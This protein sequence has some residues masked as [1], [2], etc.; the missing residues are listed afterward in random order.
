MSGAGGRVGFAGAGLA[1]A[2]AA[3]A[4]GDLHGDAAAPP[5]PTRAAAPR[6]AAAASNVIQVPS[7]VADLQSAIAQVVNGG[8]I[9]LANGTYASPTGGWVI[10]DRG[11]A[12]T[13]RAA[14]GATVV[15]DGGGARDIVRLINSSVAAGRPVTFESLVFNNGRS[16]TDGIAGG[17]TV[18]RGQATFVGCT[19]Q[20]NRSDSNTGGGGT[21]VAVGSTAFF[22]DCLWNN[23]SARTNGGGLAL[24]TDSRAVIHR[25]RFTNNRTNLPNHLAT[26]AGGAIHVVNSSLRLSNTRFTGNQAG[27]VG[28][29]VYVLGSW[30]DPVTTPRA[31]AVVANCTFVDNQAVRDGSVSFGAPTE[32]GGLHVEDQATVRVFSSRFTTNSAHVGGGLNVYRGIAEVSD[33]VFEGNRAT[34]TGTG[35]GF[36]GAISLASNDANDG[37]TGNGS[38]NRRSSALTVRD[39]LIRGR[40]GAVTTVAQVAGGIYVGGDNNRQFGWNGVA[41][42]GTMATNRATATLDNV[43][44]ADCDVQETQGA[45]GTGN[46][47]A[48][49]A[50]LGAVTLTNS[51]LIGNDAFA[52]FSYGGGLALLKS[53]ATLTGSTLAGNTAVSSGAG[54]FA[55]GS[56]LSISGGRLV[57]NDLSPGV[58]ETIGNSLGAAL[59]TAPDAG[60]NLPMTGTV[61][62]AVFSGNVGLPIVEDDRNAGPINDMRYNG[63]QIY[64]TSFGA[65]VFN[66]PI[67]GSRTTAQLN[68][69][70]VTRSGA[71]STDKSATDNTAL[72]SAPV[73]AAILAVPP[74]ILPSNAAGDPAPPTS[75]Y[76]GYAWTGGAATLDGNAVSGNFGLGSAP[77]TGAHVLSVAGT[78]FNAVVNLGADPAA[79]FTATPS[80][81]SAGAASTLAWNLTAGTY[82]DAAI[83]QGVSIT[84]AAAGSTAVTPDVGTTYRF[85]GL[86][87]EGGATGSAMVSVTGAPPTINAFT[88]NPVMV[89]AGAASTLSWSVSAGA[90]LT[91]N[92]VAVN[93]P[94]G[95]LV[96][97]PAGTT[98]YTLAATNAYGTT[99][100]TVTVNINGG[101]TTIP[102]PTI[103]QPAAGQTIGV[104]GVT[105]AWSAVSGAVAYDL[106]LFNANT[107]ALMFSGS[108]V[109]GTS[110]TT[111]LSVPT[112]GNYL[113][114]VRA[115]TG[116][117]GDANCSRF[118][119]RAFTEALIGPTAAP[120]VTFPT[121]GALLTS[122]KQTLS[123]STVA[124]NPA[125]TDLFYEVALTNLADN[126]TELQL[127]TVHPTA[128]TAATLRSGSYRLRVRACQAACGPY[129]SA[130]DFTVDLAPVPS[131]APTITG[132]TVSGGNSLN[133]SWTAVAGAEWYQV[134]AV[135]P[136]PAGPGGGALTVAS[137][138]VSGATAT[139]NIPVP[140]G[141]PSSSSPPA[142]ATAAV[143]SAAAPASTP[144][145]RTR[146][147]PTSANWSASR[148]S[149]ARARAVRLEPHP[150]RAGNNVVYRVYVQ[151]LS[152]QSAALDV[153]TTQNYYGALLKA[154]GAKYAV[155]VFANYGLPTQVQG[156]A[157]R[158]PCAA[159]RRWR[160][161]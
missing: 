70:V 33:S 41:Q 93:G 126:S 57:H 62:N 109:G 26:A 115:C 159:R 118:A 58:N 141:Q 60:L 132:A 91:L 6:A 151:D 111:L 147:C 87:E 127:R 128:Q 24:G 56:D 74:A 139:S 49:F 61:S 12:F 101:K 71:A 5:T 161:R 69:L 82:L 116:N 140:V 8:V 32:G 99:Q 158:S 76:L 120:T 10:N 17:V 160:R 50:D 119:T 73:S 11:K 143:R 121:A 1:A 136:P 79:T 9:E 25:S 23:N 20:N 16:T 55:L 42:M 102:S 148:W 106:R 95:T 67:S 46:G 152:R 44:V 43:V 104:E 53:S 18:Q 135:A 98:S 40:F 21:V 13:I 90:N 129:S 4:D 34:G 112:D 150:G 154:E 2:R 80:A 30:Q 84:P 89:V 117:I 45:S 27:Y 48:I 149:T 94:S 131:G 105:F 47:G 85:F 52:Q 19:F 155:V 130:V 114:A 97:N 122:S 7:Q 51:L 37:T 92:G 68:A 66:N 96:V 35:N 38:I 157:W 31:D 123:W 144:P 72:G 137:R 108:L 77:G 39:S 3:H 29:A 107:G 142:T 100:Q 125:L 59:Y 14:A 153:L 145:G 86:T 113:F 54:I 36:G 124:G 133:L 75:S 146:R 138:Q 110:T 28:G 63:N 22:N 15:L 64:S 83:D 78:P 81:V 65:T 88:A 103:T 134:Q 156:P